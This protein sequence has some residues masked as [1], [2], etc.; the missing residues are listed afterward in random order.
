MQ[1]LPIQVDGRLLVILKRR[2]SIFGGYTVI[3]SGRLAHDGEKLELV[4]RRGRRVLSEA[5]LESIQPVTP[6]TRIAQCRSFDLFL[7]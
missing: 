4:G 5:E 6:Q 2:N 3:E 7:L 1:W